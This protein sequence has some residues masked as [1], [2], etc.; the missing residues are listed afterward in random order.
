MLATL[1]QGYTLQFRRRPPA[2]GRVRMT[3]IRDPAKASALGQELS[4]LRAKGAIKQVDPV[5]QPGG[6]YSTYFLVPKK[7]GGF[8]P[9]LDL[10]G[11]NQFLKVLPFR[12][13]TTAEVLRVVAPGEWCTLVDLKD[14]YFHVPIAAHHQQFLRFAFQGR[15]YQFKVLPFGLSLSPRVFTRCGAAALAPLQAEGLK[16]LPYLDD[17]LVCAPSRQRARQDTARLLTH[18]GRLGLR[19]NL[20]KSSLEPS[21]RI[22]YLGV[23][24]DTAE[25]RACLSS[26]RVADILDSL[27]SFR[28][29]SIVS[30]KQL[31]RLL[32]KLTAASSVVPLGLLRLRPLQRW[33]N[34]LHLD[35]MLHGQK[36]VRISQH[37]VQSLVPWTQRAFLITGVPMGSIPSRREVVTVDACPKGWGAVWQRRA[38]RGQWSPQES[39]LHINVLELRAI[40]LALEHFAPSLRGKH[41]LVRSDNMTA[42]AQV[43][44]HGG[45]RSEQLLLEAAELLTWAAS[46]LAGLRAMYLPGDQNPVADFLSRCK[47][48]PGEWQLHPEVV[49]Q[50]WQRF[51]RAEVD[52]FATEE[53]TCCSVSCLKKLFTLKK[54]FTVSLFTNVIRAQMKTTLTLLTT[55]FSNVTHHEQCL[56]I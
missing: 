9:V 8:R 24:L 14:A 55:L 26:R 15:H 7:D 5:R 34:S 29:G 38:A 20:K 22:T 56:F 52:L 3:V 25:M 37:C 4:T 36:W 12:M 46:H 6:F 51:G 39:R 28:Q 18:I 27:V 49:E 40:R 16:V 1:T 30:Y 50:I 2:C 11:L 32:G 44:H 33:V 35:A 47:P 10:R 54:M 48:A 43:N 17:W 23:D 31:L 42:V 19:V 13:I 53:S 41:V 21:Q 45:T